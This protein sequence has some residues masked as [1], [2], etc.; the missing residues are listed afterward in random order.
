M[1]VTQQVSRDG[2]VVHISV[3]G[4]FDY[5]LS[6]QFRDAYRRTPDNN[7][8]TFNIDLSSA[9]YID[10]SGLGMMLLLRDYAECRGCSVIIQSPTE[11]VDKLLKVASFEQLFVIG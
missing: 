7:G 10:S 11:Q 4:R 8:M 3:R 9:D 2:M 5:R 1:S 6:R